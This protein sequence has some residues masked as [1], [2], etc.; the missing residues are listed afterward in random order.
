MALAPSQSVKMQRGLRVGSPCPEGN[1][2]SSLPY[3]LEEW[4][5]FAFSFLILWVSSWESTGGV[6]TS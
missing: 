2:L 6:F 5:T 3:Q 4:H 1:V